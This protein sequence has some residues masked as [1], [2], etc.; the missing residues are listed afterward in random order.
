[1]TDE[2]KRSNPLYKDCQLKLT[3]MFD[4]LIA[5]NSPLI[6]NYEIIDGLLYFK[7]FDQSTIK[8]NTVVIMCEDE[9][10]KKIRAKVKSII[11]EPNVHMWLDEERKMT[12]LDVEV[13]E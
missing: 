8:K 4:R 13:K 5:K 6:H 11:G 1:M 2:K 9:L 12:A 10:E 7:C 3:E